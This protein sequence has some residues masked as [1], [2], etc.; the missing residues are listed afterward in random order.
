MKR[1]FLFS[2]VALLAAACGPQVAKY[3][4]RSAESIDIG[5]GYQAAMGTISSSDQ[6]EGGTVILEPVDKPSVS[7]PRFIQG[8][9]KDNDGRWEEVNV[10]GYLTRDDG[11][12]S[13]CSKMELHAIGWGYELD[14][15]DKGHVAPPSGAQLK[16]WIDALDRG[17]G[18]LLKTSSS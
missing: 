13:G 11:R 1:V 7:D 8:Y 5:G 16:A 14:E 18:A 12:P 10:C 17:R 3:D 6:M 2:A 15:Q 4:Y 9:D